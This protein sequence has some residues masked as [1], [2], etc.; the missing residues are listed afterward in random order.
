MGLLA[1]QVMVAAAHVRNREALDSTDQEVLVRTAD[2]FRSLADRIRFIQSGG[3]G[4]AAETM[5]SV[6]ATADLVLPEQP[7]K[8]T[9]EMI[10]F[11]EALVQELDSLAKPGAT[12]AQAEEI[13]RRFSSI[14][15]RARARAGSS[16]HEPRPSTIP[17]F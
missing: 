3:Q 7:P 14:A 9:D 10:A 5:L 1:A 12:P 8:S 6:G 2:L 17:N 4:K 16:G 11:Y 13:Y 15:E